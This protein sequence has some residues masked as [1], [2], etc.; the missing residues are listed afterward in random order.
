MSLI[1]ILSYMCIIQ[2]ITLSFVFFMSLAFPSWFKIALTKIKGK[3]YIMKLT[4]DNVLTIQGAREEEGVYKTANGIYELE[5]EN[6]FI[7]NNTT[8]ALYYAPYNR[9]VEARVMP[10]LRTLKK[11][12][13][14]TYSQLMYYYNTPQETLLKQGG[15]GAATIG[16]TIKTY[17]GKILQ[18]LE[19]I[20]ISDLKNYLESRSPAAEN[21][22][23]ERY[24]SIER[25]K[26]GN[27][28]KNGNM[29]LMLIMAALVGLAFGYILAGGSGGVEI[30]G[31]TAA[32]SAMGGLTQIS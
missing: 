24:I 29:V 32:T 14:E 5:P 6:A 28:L 8:S 19:V 21:G 18:D 20:R 12:G 22:I 4:R 30:P 27:P 17:E 9:A 3:Q 31:A 23:I 16:E 26:L 13:I 25:R 15:E 7:F 1:S 10:L 2:S 11:A